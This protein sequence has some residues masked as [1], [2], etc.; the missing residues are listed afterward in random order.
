MIPKLETPFT[1]HDARESATLRSTSGKVEHC[2]GK[3]DA[4]LFA[5]CDKIDALE[6]RIKLA[7]ALADA[8]RK[9]LPDLD[10][11]MVPIGGGN[12]YLHCRLCGVTNVQLNMGENSRK[13]SCDEW[14]E[15]RE[16]LA[17]LEAE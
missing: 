13:H 17:A 12:P 3:S 10:C 16:A 14:A 6:A 7:D 5:A 9:K 11:L 4:Y 2:Q 1:T 15:V 8:V